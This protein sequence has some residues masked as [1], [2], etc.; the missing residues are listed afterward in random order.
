MTTSKASH[1]SLTIDIDDQIENLLNEIN[2]APESARNKEVIEDL[3]RVLLDSVLGPFGL[4]AKMLEDVDGGNVTTLHN[5]KDGVVANQADQARY[6]GWKN[7]TYDRKD[8]DKNRPLGKPPTA[9]DG[10][11]GR[12]I[13]G[14]D[15]TVDHIVSVDT[16]RHSP[17][18]H[19]AQTQKEIQKTVNHQDNLTH[20]HG[21]INS[22][23]GQH[24][25]EDWS[26]RPNPNDTSQSNTERY[27]LN[28]EM[29]KDK[30]KKARETVDGIQ[31]AAVLKKQ[32]KEFALEGSVESGK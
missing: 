16:V 23:K 2:S 22:S 25:V 17:K 31:N 18:S 9:T 11:T 5:F 13:S 7:G 8:L 20:T 12:T 15:V 26:K 27:R 4:S 3:Q 10:Y 29:V 30:N 19:L 21:S 24:D 32:A 6:E 14:H 28:E 1:E